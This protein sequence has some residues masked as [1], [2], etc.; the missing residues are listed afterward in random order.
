MQ[1]GLLKVTVDHGWD[2]EAW[3]VFS[4]HYHFVAKSPAD[5]ASLGDMLKLLHVKLAGWV[6]K[7]DA[8]AGR[9]VW[10]NFYETQLTHPTSYFARL[11]YTHQT[12][13]IMV[14]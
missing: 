9:N 6:N 11:N 5:P 3:A 4:N 14:L 1:R 7:L 8:A 10:H 13:C 12:R 2:L